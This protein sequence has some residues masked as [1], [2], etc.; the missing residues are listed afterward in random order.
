MSEK[1]ISSI[2]SELSKPFPVNVITWKPQVLNEGHTEGMAVAYADLRAYE[3]RLNE[4]CPD[5][6]SSSLQ[7]VVADGKV[8]AI[9]HLTIAGITRAGDG[10]S[11]IGDSNAFTSAYAQAFKRAASRFGLGRF[12]YDIPKTW[13]EYDDD[14]RRFPDHIVDYLNR[15]YEAMF[16]GK[17][18]PAMPERTAQPSHN[19]NGGSKRNGDGGQKQDPGTVVLKFGKYKGMTL[20][21]V[22]EKDKG[23]LEW[24]AE[25]GKNQ[26][27]AERA[28]A[29]LAQGNGNGHKEETPEASEPAPEPVSAPVPEPEPEAVPEPDFPDEVP[30]FGDDIF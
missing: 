2:M 29:V 18:A 11:P 19:G 28:K 13:V 26:W 14:K 4:V 20:N 15:R 27:I 30:D 5:D 3:D 21:Q 12:I 7:F 25:K 8:G 16:F 9:V 1:K 23:Y 10:E 17:E 24:L 22:A 6:W